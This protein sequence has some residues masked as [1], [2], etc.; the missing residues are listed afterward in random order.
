MLQS[1]FPLA[2]VQDFPSGYKNSMKKENYLKNHAT[3]E[4]K[5]PSII[6][7]IEAAIVSVLNKDGIG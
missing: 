7:N 2:D 3:E 6:D 4:R 5:N 1:N